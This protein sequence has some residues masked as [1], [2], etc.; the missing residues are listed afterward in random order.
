MVKKLRKGVYRKIYYAYLRSRAEQD[1]FFAKKA[2]L[3]IIN[4]AFFAKK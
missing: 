3:M 4:T 1:H 2:V